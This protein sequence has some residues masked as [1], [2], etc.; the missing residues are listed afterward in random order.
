MVEVHSL[1]A[2]PED[3]G[4]L[5][6]IVKFAEDSQRYHVSLMGITARL[7]MVKE[8]NLKLADKQ[9]VEAKRREALQN[10]RPKQLRRLL[11]KK[12]DDEPNL[13]HEALVEMAVKA[14][15]DASEAFDTPAPR[16]SPSPARNGSP[17]K[18]KTNKTRNT[19]A[20]LN[21]GEDDDDEEEEEE[22]ESRGGNGARRTIPVQ[23]QTD[24]SRL[25]QMREQAIQLERMSVDQ[26]R[27]QVREFR[28]NNPATLRIKVPALRQVSDE[29]IHQQ[30]DLFEAFIRN[31]RFRSLKIRN[32]KEGIEF[33]PN[34]DD[35]CIETAKIQLAYFRR[36]P[37]GARRQFAQQDPSI[38]GLSDGEIE[39][40]LSKQL[41]PEEFRREMGAGDVSTM[42]P[43]QIKRMIRSQLEVFQRN[44]Q[45]YRRMVEP[46]NPDVKNLSDAELR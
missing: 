40:K 18:S 46:Q 6:K 42:P 2:R 25:Q 22:E 21:R 20:R 5:G 26:M 8:S 17:A 27:Q 9:A 33:D 29:Q 4:K 35:D 38:A 10:L 37:A 23:R 28:M 13:S 39:A 41:N 14:E 36:D 30:R 12:D 34:S 31:P 24:P 32:M 15:L 11:K 16:A 7:V 45:E 43:E 1:Q 19:P 44:P 3:N